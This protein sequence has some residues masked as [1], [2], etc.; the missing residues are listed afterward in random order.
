MYG[1]L[2]AVAGRIFSYIFGTAAIK[3]AVLALL[4]FGV[5]LLITVLLDLLP[6]WFSADSLTGAT[7]VF[8][9]EIWFFLDYFMVSEGIGLA[10]SAYCIRF[11]I[12][13]IP[14]IG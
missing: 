11:L 9:P 1:A 12:R 2:L 7:S 3:W 8:T 13:R 5:S 6:A 4:G 14:V 10:L